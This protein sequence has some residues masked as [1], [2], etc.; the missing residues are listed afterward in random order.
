[1]RRRVKNTLLYA[2]YGG[3]YIGRNAAIDANGTTRIG[4]GYTG[5]PNSQNRAIKEV[6]FGFN[7][8]MWC[9]SALWRHQRDGSV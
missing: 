7:Q 2:Y 9:E 1:M 5:S 8:T 3:I 4:Y 6:T